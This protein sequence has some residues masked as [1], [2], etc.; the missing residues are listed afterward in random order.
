MALKGR[1]ADLV[2]DQLYI[3]D[4]P[5]MTLYLAAFRDPVA[6]ANAMAGAMADVSAPSIEVVGWHVFAGDPLT[7]RHSLVC[8]LKTE[9]HA[10]LK[11]V[12]RQIVAALAPLRDV[13]ATRDR[14]AAAWARLGDI[15]R[16]NVEAY[17]FPF[18]GPIWHPHFTLASIDEDAWETVWQAL[19]RDPPVGPVRCHWVT[20][21]RLIEGHPHEV[22]R[23]RVG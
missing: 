11:A 20:L 2:G 1:V 7:G 5:H 10:R 8:Q 17:G 14:F 4:P 9:D 13:S 18:V 6:V 16:D 19:E 3:S 22:A 15:E 12:Q 21:Y 23:H